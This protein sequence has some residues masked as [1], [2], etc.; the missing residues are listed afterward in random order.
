MHGVSRQ[1]AP[2]LQAIPP[3]A[4]LRR[5]LP[6]H[7]YYLVGGCL[8]DALLG[9][10]IHDLYIVACCDPTEL[11]QRF[12]ADHDAPWFWLDRER[13]QSRVLVERDASCL[14]FDFAPLRAADLVNDLAARD[15]TINSMALGLHSSLANSELIDP[16]DG[17]SDLHHSCLRMCGLRSF[18]ADPLRI[19]KG[20]R[21]AVALGFILEEE[22][23]QAMIHNGWRLKHVAVERLRKEVWTIL[24]HHTAEYGLQMLA[25]TGVGSVFWGTGFDDNLESLTAKLSDCRKLLCQMAKD[26]PVVAGWLVKD[27]EPD[28]PREV[29]LIWTEL[30]SIIDPT[31]PVSIAEEWLF[32]RRARA[33]I[34]SLSDLRCDLIDEL[35]MLPRRPRLLA[36]WARKYGLEPIDLLLTAATRCHVEQRGG[37]TSWLPLA[38]EA[39]HLMA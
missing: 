30:L 9:H 38:E 17:L 18:V 26:H 7:D 39:Q 6:S 8:R 16:L 22:T 15:F 33:R 14:T 24:A 31:L 13:R 12:A 34:G 28:L 2:T 35:C 37:L 20:I 29:L 1:I 11:A 5:M 36:L 3:L 21:H 23:S 27:V 4:S 32:S 19:L 10:P 25:A